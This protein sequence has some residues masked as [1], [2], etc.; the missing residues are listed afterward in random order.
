MTVAHVV[1]ALFGPRGLVGGAER[2]T[3]ELARH[4]AERVPTRL[5]TFGRE[6]SHDRIGGLEIVVVGGVRFVR[7]Q[8]S[9]PF[10]WRAVREALRASVVHCHQQHILVTTVTA[11]A[12]RAAG[13]RVFCTDLGGGGWDLSAYVSTDRLFHGHLHIS[14]YSRDVLGHRSLSRAR[15]IYGGVDTAKF[16]PPPGDGPRS[17]G[18]LFV[19]RLLPH[20]GVDVLVEALPA[21]IETEIIG[22]APDARYLADLHA[23]AVGKRV[24]FRH[25]C[26]D[27][28]LVAAYRDA[29][30][31]VLPSVCTDR[32]GGHSNVPE[33]LGQTLL[34][35]MASGA[36]TIASDAASLPE[37]VEHGVSGVI[38]GQRDV[39]GLRAALERL[40]HDR[41]EARRLGRNGRARVL[42]RF[43][44]NKVVDACLN[45]YAA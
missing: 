13:R 31:V 25:D 5:V 35:A 24:R 45:A 14:Q 9:N 42:E 27:S 43:T 20:K 29:N 16:S 7:G 32:Y 26:D 4:M 2:Y 17:I 44:W 28:A 30:V 21:D 10:A 33:L 11:L 40:H 18:C 8:R 3:L 6:P 22:P 19:G 41:D 39:A 12:A 37:I 23:L 15:V 36:A 1:P 34:E 38:V